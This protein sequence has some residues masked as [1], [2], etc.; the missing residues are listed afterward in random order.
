MHACCNNPLTWFLTSSRVNDLLQFHC[1]IQ[2]R[3]SLEKGKRFVGQ[4]SA[5]SVTSLIDFEFPNG[6]SRVRDY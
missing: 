1:I 4:V 2:F 5:D 6:E 3:L